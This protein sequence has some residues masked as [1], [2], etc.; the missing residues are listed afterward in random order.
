VLLCVVVGT[1]P[2]LNNLSLKLNGLGFYQV[3]K[4]LVTPCI[5]AMEWSLYGARMSTSRALS[6]GLVCCGVCVACVNDLAVSPA[7]CVAAAL[8]VPVAAVYKVLWSRVAKEGEWNTLS[9]MQRV[10]PGS[11]CVMLLLV[12]LID[13]P[14]LFAF[15]WSLSRLG[16]LMLSGVVAFF[17]NWSGF[18]IMGACSALTHTILGQLKACVI[19]IGGWLLFDQPYPA[20]SVAG[21][22]VAICAMVWYTKANLDEQT[23]QRAGRLSSLRNLDSDEESAACNSKPKL[24][25]PPSREP[26][27]ATVS[28]SEH[29]PLVPGGRQSAT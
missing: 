14:G 26:S 27:R 21:A 25:P 19:I 12:P 15:E 8:W 11:T 16:L 23:E 1:A 9:L 29:A 7:G 17:V 18:L 5:V 6:L 3:V 10:L 28:E 22:A 13:P 24:S 20:K 4:L 2:A